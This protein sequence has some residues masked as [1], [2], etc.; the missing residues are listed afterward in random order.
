MNSNLY[1]SITIYFILQ[2]ITD[3]PLE[4]EDI[5]QVNF[6][7][8][9]FLLWFSYDTLGGFKCTGYFAYKGFGSYKLDFEGFSY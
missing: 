3:D 9:S 6:Y 7:I 5:Q 8:I 1:I 2:E 4:D